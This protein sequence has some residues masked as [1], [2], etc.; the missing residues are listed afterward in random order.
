[1]TE[2]SLKRIVFAIVIFSISALM[3]A[4]DFAQFGFKKTGEK[5]SDNLIYSILD[6]AG[7]N[8]VLFASSTKT[9][10]VK[11]LKAL[12]TLTETFFGWDNLKIAEIK[13]I[14][15]PERLQAVILPQA[16]SF[17]NVDFLG[18]IP[19]GIQ[20]YYT[21]FLEY[22]FRMKVQ[23]Y[24]IRMQGSLFS[25]QELLARMKQAVNDPV[26]YI[27]THDP[28][29]MIRKLTELEKQDQATMHEVSDHQD[30]ILEI[31]ETAKADA[32]KLAEVSGKIVA[33]LEA[34]HSRSQDDILALQKRATDLESEAMKTNDDI[35]SLGMNVEQRIL[36]V[37]AEKEGKDLE[38]LEAINKK[39]LDLDIAFKQKTAEMEAKFAQEIAAM[40][41][42]HEQELSVMKEKS[43]QEKTAAE[44]QLRAV[45]D[46]FA[47][48]MNRGWFAPPKA[49]VDV[50]TLIG[51]IK[52]NPSLTRKDAA[53]KMKDLGSKITPGEIDIVFIVYF[54][55]YSDQ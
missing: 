28:E 30:A 49:I 36:E 5:K 22:D 2:G 45:R 26:L 10:A 48:N 55:D 43:A 41:T 31:K 51:L 44:T 20:F 8:T 52:E 15:F 54:N 29:Y 7:G 16:L 19:S 38:L 23:D 46:A 13:I 4:Q 11:D 39:T 37:E 25:E 1:M 47:A 32:L 35:E 17:E 12:Q 27:K 14:A 53:T 42:A 33:D 24:F 6:D 34:K 21:S 18:N 3:W 40:K 9:I 50:D